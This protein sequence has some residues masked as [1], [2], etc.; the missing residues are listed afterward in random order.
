MPQAG[1]CDG[2]NARVGGLN[3]AIR[4]VNDGISMVQIVEGT[5]DEVQ[6]S[7]SE[8]GISG[9]SGEWWFDQYGAALFR[10]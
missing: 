1:N 4:N 3:Q 9:A 8:C 6:A 2:L 7:C 10:Y 5:L